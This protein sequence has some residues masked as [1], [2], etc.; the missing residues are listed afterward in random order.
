MPSATWLRMS[1][2]AVAASSSSIVAGRMCSVALVMM[3]RL[4]FLADDDAWPVPA[5]KHAGTAA[6]Q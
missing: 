4:A 6:P 3:G 1:L 5:V 2:M